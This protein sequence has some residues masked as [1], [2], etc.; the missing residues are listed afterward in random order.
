MNNGEY[1]E[2]DIMEVIDEVESINHD[3]IWFVDDTFFFNK[4]RVKLFCEKMIIQLDLKIFR[5]L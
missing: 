5:R 2:R 4:E 3:K 1:T